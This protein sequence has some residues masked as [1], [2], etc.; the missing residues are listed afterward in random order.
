MFI[1]DLPYAKGLF[2]DIAYEHGVDPYMAEKD[3][4]IMHAIWGLQMQGFDFEL[5]GG[6]SLSKM[7]IISR[8]SEDID[9]KI[10]PSANDNIKIGKNHNKPAHIN[11][12]KSFFDDLATQINIPG[13]T[14]NRSE[15]FDDLKYRNAGIFLHFNSF[16][17][18]PP[19]GIKEGVLLEVGFAKTSPNQP[20]T[21]SSWAYDKAF[22]KEIDVVDNR[23]KQVKC[24]CPEYTFIEKLQ[25][26]SSKVR[27]Q[28]ETGAFGTNFLRHF[29]DL[30]KLLQ[31][32]QVKDFI[33]TKEYLSYKEEVFRNTDNPD[34]TKNLAFNL[35]SDSTLF[36]EYEKRFRDINSLF[37][38]GSISFA[39]IYKELTKYKDII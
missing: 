13:L 30:N 27:R 9:I 26:V 32:K 18:Q 23:A 7:G 14:A 4:W 34:F 24:Y 1:H 3:Y 6:T 10:N 15:E 12:R 5:K 20:I 36:A 28:Q 11:A 19:A 29:Y 25:A 33:G 31:L 38:D 21:I 8:F 39:T 17:A 22:V 2:Q 37:I 16:F 35:D